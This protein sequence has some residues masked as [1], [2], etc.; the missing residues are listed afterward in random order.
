MKLPKRQSG[1]PMT[2]M[3]D[4]RQ[5]IAMAVSARGEPA[6]LLALTLPE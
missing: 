6:E 1:V 5:Y 4:G 2:Y 3:I